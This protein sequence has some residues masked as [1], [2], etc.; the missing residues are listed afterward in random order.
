MKLTVGEISKLFDISV[1]TLHYYDEI[2][3]LNPSEKKKITDIDTIQMK[4]WYCFKKL[5]FIKIL[6]YL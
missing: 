3:L 5:F 1:R 6:C 4:I 2:N